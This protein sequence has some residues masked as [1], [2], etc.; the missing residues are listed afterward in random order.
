M[1][2][3]QT[4]AP[5]AQSEPQAA[6]QIDPTNPVRALQTFGQSVW[7]DYLRRSLF[8]SGEFKRLIDEDGLRGVTS[9]LASPA[10]S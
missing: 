8:T 2:Q 4:D 6:R 1:I 7:L 10:S 3:S 9:N 5:T